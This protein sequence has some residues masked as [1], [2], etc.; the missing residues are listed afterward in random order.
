MKRKLVRDN[1]V[2]R[3]SDPFSILFLDKQMEQSSELLRRNGVTNVINI[4]NN[5]D[6]I[7]LLILDRSSILERWKDGDDGESWN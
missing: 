6:S 1:N 3:N 2:I 4:L 5:V 7:L